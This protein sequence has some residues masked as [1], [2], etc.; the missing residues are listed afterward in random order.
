[1]ELCVLCC[2]CLPELELPLLVGI[3]DYRFLCYLVLLFVCDCQLCLCYSWIVKPID[4]VF[5]PRMS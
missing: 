5:F 1:M 4:I 3:V 2:C